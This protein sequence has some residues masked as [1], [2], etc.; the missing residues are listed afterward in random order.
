M[1][2]FSGQNL[3]CYQIFSP[4]TL[5]T[6]NSVYQLDLRNRAARPIF[7]RSADDRIVGTRDVSDSATIIVT[8]QFIQ[9]VDTEGK[10]LCQVPHDPQYREPSSIKVFPLEGRD[11]FVL[12]I[13]PSRLQS[14]S[15]ETRIRRQM[16]RISG[17]EVGPK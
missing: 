9:M 12:W 4:R 11:Q 17:S 14:Q 1:K 2:F 10:I 13:Y 8:K 7:T 3:E 5:A 16:V 6:S 15:L